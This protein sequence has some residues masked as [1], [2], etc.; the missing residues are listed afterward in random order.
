MAAAYPWFAHAVAPGQGFP[1]IPADL[2]RLTCWLATVGYWDRGY[3]PPKSRCCTMDALH[4]LAG[5]PPPG[6]DP[7]KQTLRALFRRTKKF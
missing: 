5:L 4:A 2:L 1:A 3:K 6:A 7:R